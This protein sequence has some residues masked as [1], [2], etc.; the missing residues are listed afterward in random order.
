MIGFREQDV[1]RRPIYSATGTKLGYLVS[2]PDGEWWV[3][4]KGR[5]IGRI[6]Q[7][8]VK[9]LPDGVTSACAGTYI[10]WSEIDGDC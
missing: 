5:R 10:G 9:R 6:K 3:S 4:L 7:F 2:G 8:K 1:V